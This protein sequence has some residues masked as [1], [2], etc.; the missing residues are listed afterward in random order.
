MRGAEFQT[1]RVHFIRDQKR[2]A[3][4]GR[5]ALR[6]PGPAW[7]AMTGAP[8]AG[9]GSVLPV[10]I[11]LAAVLF[12]AVLSIVNGHVLRLSSAAV[13]G[14]ELAIVMACHAVVL[15]HYRAQMLPWYAMIFAVL[16]FTLIRGAVTGQLEPK[17]A[18]DV[19]LIPTF[20]LLGMATPLRYVTRLVVTLHVIVVGGVLFEA[21][22][23]DVYASLLEVRQYYIAT[24]SFDDTAF[25]DSSSNLFV[26][27]TRPA[28]R[29]FGFIDLHRVSSVFLEPVSLGNYVVIIT[30]FLCA[31]HR[32]LS[33]AVLAFLVLGNG[34]ALIACDGRLAT[35]CLGII[36]MVSAVV[37][38][39]PRRSA[40]IYLPLALAGAIVFA[41]VTQAN[42][43]E[44]NF[45][46][47]IAFCVK[48]LS[49]YDV[50]EWLG[51][52]NRFIGQGTM[53]AAADSGIAYMITTQSVIGVVLFW[54]LLVFSADERAREQSVFLHG[55]CIYMM[56]TMLVSY[57]LFSIKT[58]A[59]V[60]FLHGAL[61]ASLA[62]ARAAAVPRLDGRR[63]P[64]S[65]A[66]LRVRPA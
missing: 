52:S 1:A 49:R 25:W 29:F 7:A 60:W 50:A 33:G 63:N 27:A 23:T 14:T 40:L 41:V 24:R 22:A 51:V 17:F 13:I 38:M 32:H 45:S 44:D 16:L 62:P 58:A 55:I 19:L 64:G 12:N 5:V 6:P 46:G 53:G 57:S 34:A 3:R 30:A 2:P 59:L 21:F 47:R 35:V 15:R 31:Y 8:A 61:Q 4:M 20:V 9:G 36:V 42:P 26:S 39:L 10:A 65:P 48:L 11:V 37:P 54:I 56:L 66:G 18:R 28:E 43:L